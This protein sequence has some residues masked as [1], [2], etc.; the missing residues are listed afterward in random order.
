LNWI[1]YPW[2]FKFIRIIQ[3]F[4]DSSQSPIIDSK[5]QNSNSKILEPTIVRYGN[6][7]S[8]LAG[9]QTT[10][11]TITRDSV[12]RPP[13]KTRFSF[14]SSVLSRH[15]V[16]YKVYFFIIDQFYKSFPWRKKS[17]GVKISFKSLFCLVNILHLEQVWKTSISQYYCYIYQLSCRDPFSPSTHL[18]HLPNSFHLLQDFTV[19]NE[20]RGWGSCIGGWSRL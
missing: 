17:K 5:N 1:E 18:L 12:I 15:L 11:D 7:V 10:I 4:S 14:I 20:S 19:L 6:A 13:L 2:I 8:V 9:K 16:L 3:I